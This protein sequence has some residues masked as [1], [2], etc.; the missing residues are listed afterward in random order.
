MPGKAEDG[1]KSLDHPQGS[2]CVL[3]LSALTGTSS[4]APLLSHRRSKF[5]VWRFVTPTGSLHGRAVDWADVMALS[6]SAIDSCG[7][8]HALEGNS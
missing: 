7:S 2:M 3:R 1:S 5:R 8:A 6:V 4:G